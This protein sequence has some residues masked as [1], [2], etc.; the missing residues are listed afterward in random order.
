MP[1]SP[2]GLMK[3]AAIVTLIVG[4]T[5][6]CVQASGDLGDLRMAFDAA[7]G[8]AEAHQRDAFDR[9]MAEARLVMDLLERFAGEM[10]YFPGMYQMSDEPFT[11]VAGQDPAYEA[12][13]QRVA[14][15]AVP[16]GSKIVIEPGAARAAR[17][18]ALK[19]EYFATL[20]RAG[21]VFRGLGGRPASH[22][23]FLGYVDW[24]A[25]TIVLDPTEGR[26]ADYRPIFTQDQRAELL[27]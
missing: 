2:G 17:F 20:Q 10:V 19:A 27:R 21:Q 1:Y 12:V 14:F 11:I 8:A 7:Q 16:A 15:L 5:G 26:G 25:Q 24:G 6:P 4:L 22:V 3:I 18:E 13:S 9:G 23:S